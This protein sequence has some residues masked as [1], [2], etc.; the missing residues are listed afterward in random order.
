MHETSIYVPETVGVPETSI[1]ASEFQASLRLLCVP[2][3]S[4]DVPET[5]GVPET[6]IN[7]SDFQA[8]PRLVGVPEKSRRP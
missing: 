2:E 7:A 8:S 4:I 1:N 6:S 3:T 5:V